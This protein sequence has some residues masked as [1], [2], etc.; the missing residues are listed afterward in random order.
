MG[1][2]AEWTGPGGEILRLHLQGSTFAAHLGSREPRNVLAGQ[3]GF[4]RWNADNTVWGV[5]VSDARYRGTDLAL[6]M[7][8]A[9]LRINPNLK[10]GDDLTCAGAHLARRANE[11]YG[12]SFTDVPRPD[13]IQ[14]CGRPDGKCMFH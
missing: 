7:V 11:T 13:R 6:A 9:A 4:I 5:H 14:E 1:N 2:I 10:S 3:V 12:T 8:G